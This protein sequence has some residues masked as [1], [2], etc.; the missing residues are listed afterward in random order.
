MKKYWILTANQERC[1]HADALHE[2]GFINWVM[3]EKFHFQIGDIVYMFMKDERRV[4][5]Q[6]E[7]VAEGCIREDKDFWVENLPDDDGRTYKL[8]LLNEYNG[9]LLNEDR[10]WDYGFK[11]GTQNPT[12][13][14]TEL[15]AYITEVFDSLEE[16]LP[17]LAD[18]PM[19]Y[20]DLFSGSYV[21]AKTG[22]EV[23]NL[24]RN[25]VDGRYYGY[26]PAHGNVT[27]TSLGAK[28]TDES[29]SG[30]I[31]VYTTKLPNSSDRKI[32]G[33]CENAKVHKEGVFDKS[34]RRIIPNERAICSYAIESDD[35][36]NLSAIED[37]FIICIAD[38]NVYMY[39]QQRFY[40]GTYPDLDE[41]VIA[42]IRSY[43]EREDADNDMSYQDEIQKDNFSDADTNIDTSKEKPVCVNGGDGKMVKRNPR[44][45]K[46][47]LHH[48]N[49]L[50]TA[51]P[52]HE[53]F[54]TEKGKPY[55][56]GHHLIPCTSSNVMS[57]WK[58]KGVNI[59]CEENVVC[60][61][62]TCHRKIHYG[63]KVEKRQIIEALYSKHREKLLRVG[64]DITL[65]EL[66]AYY[67]I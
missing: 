28:A 17:E 3:G 63:S 66:Y 54:L 24:D 27:I 40:K 58:S 64:L 47:S 44:V 37:P 19:L 6:L 15:T 42:Y 30:V 65:E 46:Q 21:A 9:D 26:C 49:Y 23:Y 51:N 31:V 20:V 55:M 59:D 22:H 52:K 1:K 43:L 62:P 2:I 35:L 14:N 45:A 12:Y 10:L 38:Y 7:V 53:T 32:I 33:F 36:V 8:E 67:G 11:G 4:R 29:I 18:R 5:F 25:P 56:E 50:C 16:T 48:S 13:K 60:L 34:L 41:K 61:C 57:L 39:R